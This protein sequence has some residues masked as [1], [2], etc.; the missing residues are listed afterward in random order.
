MARLHFEYDQHGVAI[1]RTRSIVL[2][3]SLYISQITLY[4]NDEEAARSKLKRLYIS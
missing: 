1:H 3:S 2:K 4:L